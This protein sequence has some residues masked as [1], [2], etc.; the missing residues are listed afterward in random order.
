MIIKMTVKDLNA[1]YANEV[2]RVRYNRANKIGNA[3]NNNAQIRK[4]EFVRYLLDSL[5][6]EVVLEIENCRGD[7]DIRTFDLANAGSVVE[8]IVKAHLDRVNGGEYSKAWHDDDND[9]MNG[10]IAWE[11]KASLESHFLATPAQGD[12]ATLLVNRDGVSLIRKV[13]V[14]E[15]VNNRGRLPA[16][17]TYGNRN[18]FMVK[19]L[20]QAL[21]LEGGLED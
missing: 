17:G 9:A 6:D 20:E 11:V 2:E 21:G 14:L 5:P 18:N 19:F 3:S 10:C 15:V 13:E 7:G 4:C 8:C 16:A 12:K 1:L